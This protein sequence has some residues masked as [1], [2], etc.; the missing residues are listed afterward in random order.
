MMGKESEDLASAIEISA[1]TGFE[2]SATLVRR[3]AAAY[4]RPAHSI[5]AA[6]PTALSPH[7]GDRVTSMHHGFGMHA[8]APDVDAGEQEQPDHVDEMPVPGGELEAEMLGRLELTGKR[9]QQAYREKDRPDDHMRAMEAGRHEEGRAVDVA[10]EGEMRVAVLVSL[11]A[12]ERDAEQDRADQA[13]FEALAIVLEQRMM[14]P[15]HRGAGGEQDQRVEQRQVPGIERLDPLRRPRPAPEL[16]AH[17]VVDI[18][19]EQRGV[20]IGPE[21]RDEEHHLG[22]DE[23]DHAVAVRELHHARMVPLVLGFADDVA[24]PADHGAHDPYRA[25]VEDDRG[26][27]R[28]ASCGPARCPPQAWAVRG[29]DTWCRTA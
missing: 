25:E 23:Q 7:C 1:A 26:G 27:S 9:A 29:P 11:D 8:R 16:G 2:I 24:P 20:E 13:P 3:A 15:G 14:R 10:F 6:V 12:G 21:P 17:H 28:A 18:G 4:G 5:R 22:S 19:R